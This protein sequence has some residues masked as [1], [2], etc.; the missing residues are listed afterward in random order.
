MRIKL[1]VNHLKVLH[2]QMVRQKWFI[3]QINETQ[4]LVWNSNFLRKK[5]YK[6]CGVQDHSYQQPAGRLSWQ[7][8]G[9]PP[10]ACNLAASVH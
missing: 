3:F 8:C 6:G 10:L 9:L 2:L 4:S 1:N 7:D 5:Y